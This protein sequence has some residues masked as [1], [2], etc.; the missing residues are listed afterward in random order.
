MA[1]PRNPADV[2][3]VLAEARRDGQSV[4]PIGSG[5]SFTPVAAT[6]GIQVRLDQLTGLIRTDVDLDTGSGTATVAAGTS[7]RVFNADLA[8]LGLGLANMGDI[9]LQTVSGA[10]STGTH[11]SGR[12]MASLSALVVGLEIVLP[13]GSL[14]RCSADVEPDLFQA[15][16]LG[17]GALG[18]VTS[19]TFRVERAFLLH[20]VEERGHLDEVLE[21]FDDYAGAAH[22]D[23]YWFPF[24]DY[25]QVK[26]H[27]RTDQPRRPMS[28]MSAWWTDVGENTGI[29]IVQRISRAAPRYTPA[30][31]LVAG[32]LISH[33]D[34]ID[35]APSV[36]TRARRIRWHE[37]E[38]ALPRRVAVPAI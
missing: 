17:L 29:G 27:R 24:T 37:M 11:G 14:A 26:R 7:M 3:A 28:T 30:V 16:R 10:V 20:G 31:N 18:I 13:D 35:A 25:M 21:R 34:Y 4:K 12:D 36:F 6:D 15:A 2:A 38:Y 23:M 9:D 33:R 22:L 8:R 32:R 1:S 19:L 5:H